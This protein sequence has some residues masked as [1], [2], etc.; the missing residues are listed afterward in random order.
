MKKNKIKKLLREASE[1]KKEDSG[2]GA[3]YKRIQNLLQ[4]DIFNHAGIIEKLWGDKDATNRSLFRKKLNGEKTESG[5]TYQF[6]KDEIDEIA[7]ILMDT[8]VDIDKHIGKKS[9]KDE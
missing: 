4:N 8:S 3:L 2:S 9:E 1:E 5:K 7:S 6:T